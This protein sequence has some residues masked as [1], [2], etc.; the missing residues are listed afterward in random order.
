MGNTK[1][2]CHQENHKHISH[3]GGG[4]S[5]KFF[6]KTPLFKNNSFLALMAFHNQ[7]N[8]HPIAARGW[9][10]RGFYAKS[11]L[12]YSSCSILRGDNA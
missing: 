8:Y 9:V 1:K 10:D 4:I 11:S 3:E 6:V 5:S 12:F 7:P 2:S